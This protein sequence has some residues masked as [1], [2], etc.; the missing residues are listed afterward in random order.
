MDNPKIQ[1]L[2]SLYNDKS[3]T[4]EEKRTIAVKLIDMDYL[5][6]PKSVES[7]TKDVVSFTYDGKRYEKV[8]INQLF[9]MLT[10]SVTER[11][12][13]NLKH[14]KVV[15]ELWVKGE[16]IDTLKSRCK[17]LTYGLVFVII[18]SIIKILN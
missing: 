14:N 10:D 17:Y 8:N 1:K 7:K 13:I 5:L 12:E 6:K 2:L 16:E 15:S 4:I 9:S 3:I 18:F 11:N